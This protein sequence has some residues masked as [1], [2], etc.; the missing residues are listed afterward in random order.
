MKDLWIETLT[1]WKI[2]QQILG[3]ERRWRLSQLVL[4][5][6]IS[7]QLLNPRG[8]LFHRWSESLAWRYSF[9]VHVV[10]RVDGRACDGRAKLSFVRY[11][12]ASHVFNLLNSNSRQI[13]SHAWITYSLSDVIQVQGL[14]TAEQNQVFP[15]CVAPHAENKHVR[16]NLMKSRQH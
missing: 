15:L 10:V 7:L 16:E 13:R 5:R 6:T 14:A 3:P 12:P 1:F 9:D 11:Q 2:T 4:S 8:I